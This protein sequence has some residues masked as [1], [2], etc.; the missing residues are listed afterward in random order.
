[1]G[2]VGDLEA[3][4][5]DAEATHSINIHRGRETKVTL[6]STFG[7]KTW[8]IVEHILVS[9]N[10]LLPNLWCPHLS[11]SKLDPGLGSLSYSV[12]REASPWPAPYCR[13]DPHFPFHFFCFSCLPNVLLQPLHSLPPYFSPSTLQSILLPLPIYV[14]SSPSP[15]LIYLKE[16]HSSWS[17]MPKYNGHHY[18]P[19]FQCTFPCHT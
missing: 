15:L 18:C 8:L 16:N 2:S 4:H 6:R 14:L 5:K 17:K 12:Q 13:N 3:W 10:T 7:F 1:M 19:S 11:T 9:W